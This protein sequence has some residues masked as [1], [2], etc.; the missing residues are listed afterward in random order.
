MVLYGFR[1][2]THD[3]DLGCS[4]ALADK[5]ERQ[6]YRVTRFADG[7]RKIFYSDDIE[8]FEN[9]IDGAVEILD[10]IPIVSVDGLIRMKKRLG[11]EKDLKDIELIEQMK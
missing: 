9:W 10:G 11:R 4:T 3:V 1:Q 2:Q 5:L 8:I 7:T 6:G